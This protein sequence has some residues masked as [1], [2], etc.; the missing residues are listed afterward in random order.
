LSAEQ[1]IQC[2]GDAAIRYVYEVDAGHDFE[3]LA[4][5]MVGAANTGDANSR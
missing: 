2:R 1:V 5:D 4:G 3:Q